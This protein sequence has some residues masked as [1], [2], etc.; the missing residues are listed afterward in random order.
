MVDAPI[1]ADF[2]LLLRTGRWPC[3]LA[4]A[5][6]W[7]TASAVRGCH[8]QPWETLG[9]T[10]TV[11]GHWCHVLQSRAGLAEQEMLRVSQM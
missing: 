10:G 1:T 9:S 5:S 6:S 4:L 3:G 2:R 11:G 8:E 7:R